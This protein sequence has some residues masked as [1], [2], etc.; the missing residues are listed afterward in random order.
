MKLN[1][2][3]RISEDDARSSKIDDLKA[4]VADLPKD[5]DADVGIVAQREGFT[6]SKKEMF[7]FGA[8]R[9]TT[10]L[11]KNEKLGGLEITLQYI[12]NPKT[13][14][15]C[16]RACLAG[17][18]DEDMVEFDTGE[19]PSSLIENLKKKTKVTPH[20]AVEYLNPPADQVT[21]EDSLDESTHHEDSITDKT[22]ISD[23]ISEI[24]EMIT[25]LKLVD[26][27]TQDYYLLIQAGHVL[28]KSKQELK[29][30]IS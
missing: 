30:L 8:T 12:I 19:D 10:L 24:S 3:Y 9:P 26:L 1:D 6:K 7:A 21:S 22:V 25:K 27:P 14:A 20:Q 18:S 29:S 13:G 17:Q 28:D 4:A 11:T 23:L 16:L 2:L 5:D 15:W